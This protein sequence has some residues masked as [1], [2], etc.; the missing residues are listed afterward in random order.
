MEAGTTSQ[1]DPCQGC[2]PTSSQLSWSLLANGSVCAPGMVCYEGVC[3]NKSGNCGANECGDDGCGGICGQ[4]VEGECCN[5]DAYCARWV[6]LNEGT[7]EDCKTGRQW[8]RYSPFSLLAQWGAVDYC[9][10]LVLDGHDDWRLP[11]KDELTQLILGAPIDGCRI[12]PIF[13]GVCESY[14]TSTFNNEVFGIVFYWV[15]DFGLGLEGP[16]NIVYALRYRCT[17]P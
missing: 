2:Q 16:Y 13:D 3:C 4:C 11:E 14:W 10:N 1:E 17:R 5:A 9:L 12:D 8:Q 7:V 6:A 15:V